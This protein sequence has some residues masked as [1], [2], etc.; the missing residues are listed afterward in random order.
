DGILA[1]MHCTD[2]SSTILSLATS[3]FVT[4]PNECSRPFFWPLDQGMDGPW[5]GPGGGWV[6]ALRR[7]GIRVGMRAGHPVV[8]VGPCLPGARW[9]SAAIGA[10]AL[11][12]V[13]ERPGPGAR[14]AVRQAACQAEH[15]SE[16]VNGGGSD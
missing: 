12:R 14:Q 7:V 1:R 6:R 8:E 16:R 13:A 11:S 10:R 5:T 4:I 3:A 15:A 9:G 2:S